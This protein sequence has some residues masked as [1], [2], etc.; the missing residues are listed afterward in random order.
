[1][2][3]ELRKGSSLAPAFKD[4]YEAGRLLAAVVEH[5]R[6]RAPAV[7]A[8]PRGGVPLGYEVA[9]VLQ[10]PLDLLLVRKLAVPGHPE[11]SLGVVA[12]GRLSWIDEGSV[13]RHHVS[14][15]D[16][17]E[18]LYREMEEVERQAW[19][20]RRGR[21][22]LSLQGRTVLVVDDGVVTGR[23]GRFAL[24]QVRKAKPEHVLFGAGVIA[25]RAYPELFR[26]TDGVYC[27]IVPGSFRSISEWYRNYD[28]VDDGEVER[29]LAAV[30]EL[31]ERGALPR[32]PE[33][34]TLV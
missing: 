17:D 30:H 7:V 29:L 2:R 12:E 6:S 24:E 20:Y 26:Y 27:P 25:P 4:R 19:A 33:R 13:R 23:T 5:L 16:V 3:Q 8:L 1:M 21:P 18:L 10:A 9:K 22:R 28:P 34:S 15:G 32:A 14:L 31:H 11:E